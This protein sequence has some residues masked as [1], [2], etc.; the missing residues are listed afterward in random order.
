MKNN[1]YI[2]HVPYLRNSVP[3]DHDFWCTCVKR[4]FFNFFYVFISWTDRG[5]GGVKRQKVVQD[6]KKILLHFLSQEPYIIWFSFMVHLCIMMISRG[7]FFIFPK[8][9]CSGLLGGWGGGVKGQKMV[10]N[11]KKFCLSRSISQ[12]SYIIWIS[13]MALLCKMII[14]QGVFS[15]FQNF[16]FVGC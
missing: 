8:F 14:S 15:V 1:N 16:D 11:Q 7:I 13:F 3:Y 2:C 4:C 5:G 12:E 10:Q 6:D 9:W